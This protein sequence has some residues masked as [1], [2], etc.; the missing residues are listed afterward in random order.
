M[1][2]LVERT[3]AHLD[4]LSWGLDWLI[5]VLVVITTTC[6]TALIFA[7]VLTRYV[8]NISIIWSVEMSKLLF[9]WS[10]FLSAT[11]AFRRKA[12]IRFEFLNQVL[13]PRGIALTDIVFYLSALILFR[14][15]I[16]YGTRFARIV[17]GT[18][19]PVMDVSQ[20]WLYVPVVF[21]GIV[22]AIHSLPMLGQSVVAFIT[23]FG[24]RGETT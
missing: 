10:A 2:G 17:W 23:S 5:R 7:A 18:T 24:R 13:G 15:F 14:I 3:I 12:H 20:G 4:R 1:T 9:I 11:V 6:F 19:L 8:L 22:M 21:S 16:V